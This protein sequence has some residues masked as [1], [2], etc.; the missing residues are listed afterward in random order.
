MTCQKRGLFFAR[1][2][3][4]FIEEVNY[5][6]FGICKVH[7]P[8]LQDYQAQARGSSDLFVRCSS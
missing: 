8:Q 6:S 2:S 4:Q 5:E 3:N 7:L 1:S